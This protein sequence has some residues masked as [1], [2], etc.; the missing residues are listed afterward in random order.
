MGSG[1]EAHPK[2]T[3]ASSRAEKHSFEYVWR[4][5]LAGGLAGCVAKTVISPL[6]RVKILFQGA[7]PYYSR[8]TGVLR[9]VPFLTVVGS[10]A[11]AFKALAEI[12]REQG[13]AGLYRG[14]SAMLLRIFPYSAISYASHEQYNRLLMPSKDKQDPWRRILSGSLA[15]ATAVTVTYP[16][17]LMRARMAFQVRS[18]RYNNVVHA[19]RRMMVEEGGIFAL[20][21]GFVPTRVFYA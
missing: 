1:A 15:G 10:T 19:M 8:Y 5:L 7:N 18:K 20:Y 13:R 4:S 14:H 11:G 6:D 9:Q 12:A 17:D 16:L 21:K 3:P 2:K